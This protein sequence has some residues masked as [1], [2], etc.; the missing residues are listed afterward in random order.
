ELA[1][2]ALTKKGNTACVINAANEIAV[3]AFLEGRIKF[4]DI[5]DLIV[6]ALDTM[7]YIA[8]PTLEDYVTTNTETRTFTE[9]L[10]N[11]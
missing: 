5:H 7:P 10:I 11:R 1:R 4:L 3:A 6:K 9:S 2:T 8:S